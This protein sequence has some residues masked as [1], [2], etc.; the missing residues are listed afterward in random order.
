MGLTT[1]ESEETNPERG[2]CYWASQGW[3]PG[4]GV[5]VVSRWTWHKGLALSESGTKESWRQRSFEEKVERRMWNEV[6]P[7]DRCFLGEMGNRVSWD[8]SEPVGEVEMRGMHVPGG[9]AEVMPVS[10]L[11]SA[12]ARQAQ[13]GWGKCGREWSASPLTSWV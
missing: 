2:Q 1:F 3:G 13:G 11:C 5:G 9:L 6:V 10:L 7:H 4:N 12:R 8:K